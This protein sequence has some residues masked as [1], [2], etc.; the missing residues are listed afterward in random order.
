MNEHITNVAQKLAQA[1]SVVVSTGAGVSRESGVPTFREA[2]DGLWARFDPQQ[3]ATPEAFERNPKLVWEWYAYRRDL[4]SKSNPNPGHYALAE[5]EQ[6]L[7][8]MLLVTQNVDHHHHRAGSQ[9]VIR[10]HGDLFAFK[11]SQN[12]QGA[13]TPIETFAEGES[14]PPRCPFCATG[15]VRPDVVWFGE[16]LPQAG[17]HRAFDEAEKCDVMLIVG[18]SGMVYPAAYLPV[19]AHRALLVE[20]NP[21]HSELSRR[22]D[23][24]LQGP[25]GEVLPQVVEALKKEL[26]A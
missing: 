22:M 14:T 20:V 24:H 9:N 6:L 26:G 11:C 25:S 1:K 8:N 18:T 7:P 15:Y 10:L 16:Q 3:L 21:I 17:L 2:Q 4:V 23:V 19:K 12:C 13:P 5:M